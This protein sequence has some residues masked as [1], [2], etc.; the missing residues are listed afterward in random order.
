MAELDLIIKNGTV[1]TAS[2]T[3]RADVGI[4][5]GTIVALG[6]KLTQLENL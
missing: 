5:N 6:D 3:F 4:R 2:D 1:A